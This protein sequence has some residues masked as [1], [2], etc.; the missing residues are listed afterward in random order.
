MTYIMCKIRKAF[1]ITISE[2]NSA[3]SLSTYGL[4]IF[5]YI[6]LQ[7]EVI[8]F[9]SPMHETDFSVLM[10]NKRIIYA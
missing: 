8:F 3:C 1:I 9:A 6:I 4:I 7:V 5:N 10:V 2:L